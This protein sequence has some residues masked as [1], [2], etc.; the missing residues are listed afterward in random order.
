M[1]NGSFTKQDEACECDETLSKAGLHPIN[2]LMSVWWDYT[3]TF[4]LE[5]FPAGEV[6]NSKKYCAQ[7]A[8]LHAAMKE[9]RYIWADQMVSFPLRQSKST[10]CKTDL[11][12]A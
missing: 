5:I 10:C 1:K 7:L 11:A 6:V 4:L 2:V 12:E 9:T 8:N 3:G